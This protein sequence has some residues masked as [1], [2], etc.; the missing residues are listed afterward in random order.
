MT[1]GHNPFL[2]TRAANRF[3]GFLSQLIHRRPERE[4]PTSASQPSV[5]PEETNRTRTEDT[6]RAS[7]PS[8]PTRPITPPPTLPPPALPELGLS[9][10]AITSVLTPSH[11]STPPTSGT[12]LAPH[13]LLLCHS[14]GLDV[15]PLVSPPAPQPY[16]LVRRVSF[17]SVVVMEER[18]VL[19]AIAGRRDGV[20]V[21]ALEEVRKAVEWRIDVEVRRERDRMRREEAKKGVAGG[22]DRVFGELKI[23]KGDNEKYIKAR[24]GDS[25]TTPTP[26]TPTP[27]SKRRKS[28]SIGAEASPSS[29]HE[30]PRPRPP[31]IRRKSRAVT[32]ENV[33]TSQH[34]SDPPPYQNPSPTRPP[35]RNQSSV[36]SVAQTRS[37]TGSIADVLAGT[38]VRRRSAITAN[39][40]DEKAD[41]EH[42]SSDDEAINMTTAGNSGS[43]AL[44]ERTSSMA[45]G[46]NSPGV[47]PSSSSVGLSSSPAIEVP[48]I[49]DSLR[50]TQT[51]TSAAPTLNRRGRPT[52]LDLSNNSN[53]ATRPPPSPTPTVWTLRQALS[54]TP[55][56]E[57]RPNTATSDADNDEDE[58]EE[59]GDSI[60]F[61]QALL[62]SRLP[63]LPPIGT[64]QPQEAILIGSHMNSMDEPQ[65]P[66]DTN[67]E[68][69][70]ARSDMH[71][72]TPSSS[73]R[74]RR[75][76]S[77]FDGVFANSS[78]HGSMESSSIFSNTPSN[79]TRP[80]TADSQMTERSSNLLTRIG[81]ADT[82]SV[83]QRTS[84][85]RGP[86][87]T[88]PVSRAS[89]AR[90]APV[91]GPAI[92]PSTSVSSSTSHHRFLPRIFTNAFSSRRS[93]EQLHALKSSHS[94]IAK[95][96]TG[97]SLPPIPPA[98][99]L[100]YVKLPGTKGAVLIKAVE[101]AKKR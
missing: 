58:D 91:S 10:T 44:D 83:M 34:D 85:A 63:D 54:Y 25:P 1:S 70:G 61:A 13:F 39:R 30:R 60:T 101:T 74:S 31:T 27:K 2:Q 7:S 56:G 87:P 97:S 37:R 51:S 59:G 36:I 26:P 68:I 86:T 57:E 78:S 65:S 11:F 16:A 52:Q 22:V 81:S 92:P 21:Y 40:D 24:I 17:K 6:S 45:T 9:L 77:V 66:M 79:M 12:F 100:E 53:T 23:H 4:L 69:H 96:Q 48:N 72:P 35:L 33:A 3:S 50:R 28:L 47:M 20:R 46:P 64:R 73:R 99:K 29:L 43:A 62:E 32:Q 71:T 82:T 8:P 14:Q 98:P 75:R 94:D 19:V 95:R 89:T 84:S 41:W 80:R 67:S 18:G 49:E 38:T 55:P 15:L 76:W 5:V 93:E 88:R 90:T 42:G